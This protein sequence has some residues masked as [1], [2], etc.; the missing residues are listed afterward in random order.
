ME[1]I[2]ATCGYRNEAIHEICRACGH[3]MDAQVG[4]HEV[5][6]EEALE[7]QPVPAP[8]PAPARQSIP[9]PPPKPTTASVVSPRKAYTGPPVKPGRRRF[10]A[11]KRRRRHEQ[12]EQDAR[13]MVRW[14]LVVIAVVIVLAHRCTSG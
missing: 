7:P 4:A 8:P 14:V 6:A 2:C 11:W 1:R 10:M 13:R 9:I 5:D 3:I 12:G